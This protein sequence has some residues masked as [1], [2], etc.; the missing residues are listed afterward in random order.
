MKMMM[1]IEQKA[2]DNRSLSLDVEQGRPKFYDKWPNVYCGLV[3][4]PN[5]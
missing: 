3:G 4:V 2:T 5:F 1:M